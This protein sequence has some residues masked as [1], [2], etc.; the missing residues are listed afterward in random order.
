[1]T[2]NIQVTMNNTTNLPVAP[3]SP[4]EAIKLHPIIAFFCVLLVLVGIPGN[5]FIL[6]IYT[7]KINLDIFGFFIK[8]LAVLDLITSIGIIPASL[9]SKIFPN[10]NLSEMCKY[11]TFV[12]YFSSSTTG[13]LYVVIAVQRFMKIC[14][15][16]A[17]QLKMHL[18]RKVTLGCII[19]CFVSGLPIVF[20]MTNSKLQIKWNVNNEERLVKGWTCD[21][22][23]SAKDMKISLAFSSWM[24]IFV[25]CTVTSLTVLYSKIG[26][27]LREHTRNMSVSFRS[28]RRH[29]TSVTV[30]ATF[31]SLTIIY[32]VSVFPRLVQAMLFSQS[33]ISSDLTFTQVQMSDFAVQLP[34]VNCVANLFIYG[35][36]SKRFR[37]VAVT[38]LCG[39]LHSDQA[40]TTDTRS[41]TKYSRT[42]TEQSRGDA[43]I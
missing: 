30:T 41:Q 27:K 38:V 18:A 10:I 26:L 11:I 20:I 3:I 7:K 14:H 22:T 33:V 6:Y 12:C 2:S 16:H 35:F 21:Y 23:E 15:P 17:S 8:T 32:V 1:M 4:W 42:Q 31:F 19:F 37:R 39:R 24:F 28:T 5:C 25:V 43:I 40:V 9:I 29:K 36:S 13:I 34:F